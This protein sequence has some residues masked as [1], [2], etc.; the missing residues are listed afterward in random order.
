[1]INIKI[2]ILKIIIKKLLNK[3]Y[4]CRLIFIKYIEYYCNLVYLKGVC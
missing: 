3:N 4:N 2:G 1:M